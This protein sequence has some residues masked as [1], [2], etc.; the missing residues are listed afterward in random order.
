M[1]GTNIITTDRAMLEEIKKIYE[2]S[3][4]SAEYKLDLIYELTYKQLNPR[5]IIPTN[6][7]LL[8]EARKLIKAK[9][10]NYNR[11]RLTKD[12]QFTFLK[13]YSD[14]PVDWTDCYTMTPFIFYTRI[15]LHH[16]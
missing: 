2:L 5:E 8:S 13:Y 16:R 3:G 14:G 10:L 6:K 12:G 7:E 9:D 1:S 15:I 11:L 4:D